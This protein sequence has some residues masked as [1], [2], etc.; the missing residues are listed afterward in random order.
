M[1]ISHKCEIGK[2]RV[3]P[4]RCMKASFDIPE[5]R[6]NFPSTRVFYNGN[7]MKLVYQYMAMFHPLHVIFIHYKSR[8]ATAIRGL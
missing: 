5:N 3:K 8:I 1:W 6:L 2:G 7:S 4:S